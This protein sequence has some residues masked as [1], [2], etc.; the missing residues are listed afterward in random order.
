MKWLIQNG[1]ILLCHRNYLGYEMESL[2]KGVINSY[3]RA[4]DKGSTTLDSALAQ[5]QKK[6]QVVE[7][8]MGAYLKVAKS[9]AYSIRAFET[10]KYMAFHESMSFYMPCFLKRKYVEL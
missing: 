2:I 4:F 1:Q 8:K 3:E 9:F 6:L 7:D 10:M 5:V